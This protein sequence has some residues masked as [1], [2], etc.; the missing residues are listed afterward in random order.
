MRTLQPRGTAQSRAIIEVQCYLEDAIVTPDDNISS[1]DCWK[2]QK[3]VYPNLY[4]L[5]V[6]NLNVLAT[7]VPCKGIFSAF[8][9]QEN[10]TRYTRKTWIHES[11]TTDVFKTK[12]KL[13]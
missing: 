8:I 4:S 9:M 10:D 12:F 7:S 3:T 13:K 1:L 11:S 5:V 2:Q 6:K